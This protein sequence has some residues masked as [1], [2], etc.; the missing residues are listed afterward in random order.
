MTFK[1]RGNRVTEVHQPYT[2][3]C[4]CC[5]LLSQL[6]SWSAKMDLVLLSTSLKQ[7]SSHPA[8]TPAPTTHLFALHRVRWLKRM[9]SAIT[10]FVW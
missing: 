1:Y 10:T 5:A 7:W 9:V 2:Y 6:T 3:R 8:R 4:L